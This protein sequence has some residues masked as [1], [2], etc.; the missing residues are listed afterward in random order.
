MHFLRS[1]SERSFN[2]LLE[3][4]HGFW[5]AA[6][7]HLDSRN[8]SE[9]GLGRRAGAGRDAPFTVFFGAVCMNKRDGDFGTGLTPIG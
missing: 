3:E 4:T 2:M 7:T 6:L 9:E 8:T 1:F 5:G